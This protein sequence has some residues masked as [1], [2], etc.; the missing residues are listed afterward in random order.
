ML[1]GTVLHCLESA[2]P[3][4]MSTLCGRRAA[5][6][7]GAERPSEAVGC[8]WTGREAEMTMRMRSRPP[9]LL[10]YVRGSRKLDV[11][12]TFLLSWPWSTIIATL[13]CD[14]DTKGC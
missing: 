10:P 1:E 4:S 9:M 11:P 6:H 7:Y 14:H 5:V 12:W 8:M 2:V 3:E 13:I